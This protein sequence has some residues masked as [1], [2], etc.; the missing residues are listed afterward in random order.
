MTKHDHEYGPVVAGTDEGVTYE[1]CDKCG[2]TV[3]KDVPVES[4]C[5]ICGEKEPS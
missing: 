4:R 1:K 5:R 3:V 2:S